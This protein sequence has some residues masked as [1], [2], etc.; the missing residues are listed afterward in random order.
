MI[1]GVWPEQID[2][3]NHLRSD[4]RISNLRDVGV[5]ENQKNR[6]RNSN[7][8]SGVTGVSWCQ[9]R[10]DWVVSIH[11][12][13]KVCA[14]GRFKDFDAAIAARKQAEASLGFH[15]NHGAEAA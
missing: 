3:I 6:S 9:T 7:N 11:A 10:Q 8:T 15:P 5:L 14:V 12:S 1:H 2:H 13:G 4:N